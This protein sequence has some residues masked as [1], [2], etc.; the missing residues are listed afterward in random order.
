M[1]LLLYLT[2]Q[3][4]T[5]IKSKLIY[6]GFL[7]KVFHS[8][9][10]SEQLLWKVCSNDTNYWNTLIYSHY[11]GDFSSLSECDVSV[12][13]GFFLS[14]DYRP[15]Q[16]ATTLNL[17]TTRWG[18]DDLSCGGWWVT[19]IAASPT[20]SATSWSSRRRQVIYFISMSD[21][22]YV[23]IIWTLHVHNN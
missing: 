14:L 18:S 3:Y 9:T 2:T 19:R 6:S 17:L 20:F 15:G 16:T 21:K 12:S 11:F 1:Q 23:I 22:K 13:W 7:M 8:S 4:I 5:M 10:N